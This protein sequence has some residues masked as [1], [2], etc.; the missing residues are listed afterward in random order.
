MVLLQSVSNRFLEGQKFST[1][2]GLTRNLRDYTSHAAR[3]QTSKHATRSK[4]L[5]RRPMCFLQHHIQKVMYFWKSRRCKILGHSEQRTSSARSWSAK[6]PVILMEKK[7]TWHLQKS[8]KCYGMKCQQ[9]WNA[10]LDLRT[11]PFQS[12]VGKWMVT[13]TVVERRHSFTVPSSRKWSLS[14]WQLMGSRLHVGRKMFA[15][16]HAAK[17]AQFFC[18][19]LTTCVR[20]GQLTVWTNFFHAF[21]SMLISNREISKLLAPSSEFSTRLNCVSQGRSLPCLTRNTLT[22]FSVCRRWQSQQSRNLPQFPRRSWSWMMTQ[23]SRWQAQMRNSIAL[24]WDQQSIC[25]TT[26]EMWCTQSKN[27]RDRWF[28]LE[29]QTW[30]T[31]VCLLAIWLTP[32]CSAKSLTSM[33]GKVHSVLTLSQTAIGLETLLRGALPTESFVWSAEQ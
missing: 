22:T 14:H 8:L 28:V 1:A 17:L 32:G 9:K 25:H 4:S 15:F 11:F 6:M 24:A 26:E 3:V 20:Q 33:S 16:T 7:C 18:T 13:S 19:M 21:S 31:C 27:L 29:L 12:F 30:S 10:V 2:S 5:K 23:F